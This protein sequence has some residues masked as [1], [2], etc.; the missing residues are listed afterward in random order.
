MTTLKNV[1][2]ALE[3]LRLQEGLTDNAL[4]IRLWND[5]SGAVRR[6]A[7]PFEINGKEII[8]PAQTSLA[9]IEA[10]IRAHIKPIDDLEL[11]EK[12]IKEADSDKGTVSYIELWGYRSGRLCSPNGSTIAMW[13]GRKDMRKKLNEYI[14]G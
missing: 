6:G 9:D 2:D 13:N 10:A 8:W 4:Y 7:M 12:A 3:E 11:M 14:R 1:T 5:G